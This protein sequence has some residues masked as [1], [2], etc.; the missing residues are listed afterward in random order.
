MF[1]PNEK[2]RADFHAWLRVTL[3]N[4][5]GHVI[6][7]ANFLISQHD[8]GASRRIEISRFQTRSGNPEFYTF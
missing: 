2:Q 3:R 7:W 4:P 1:Y 8:W 5:D 6:R